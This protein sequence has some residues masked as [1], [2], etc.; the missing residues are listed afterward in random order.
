MTIG[1]QDDRF[2]P[3]TIPTILYWRLSDFRM[4]GCHLHAKQGL[5]WAISVW[6]ISLNLLSHLD[7]CTIFTAWVSRFFVSLFFPVTYW[8]FPKEFILRQS[9]ICVDAFTGK[10]GLKFYFIH[11][12]SWFFL[13]FF[14]P[15]G[16]R[17]KRKIIVF[18]K[19]FILRHLHIFFHL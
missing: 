17:V 4:L 6:H 7:N 18:Q 16:M 10:S 13:F 5:M 19:E 12:V 9:Q 11:W 14:W 1:W 2:I 15:V 8:L 3:S